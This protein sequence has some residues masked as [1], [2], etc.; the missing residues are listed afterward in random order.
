MNKLLL[1]FPLL[2]LFSCSSKEVKSTLSEKVSHTASK[3][4]TQELECSNVEMVKTDIKKMTDKI[5]KVEEQ[6]ESAKI[7]ASAVSSNQMEAVDAKVVICKTVTSALLP[8]IIDL[9]KSGKLTSWGCQV[10]KGEAVIV[11]LVHK[12]CD[13]LAK[14]Q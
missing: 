4:I 9:A 14:T 12:G 8:T 6:K 3:V 7:L 13:R 1:F 10:D 5:L 11:D 2:L